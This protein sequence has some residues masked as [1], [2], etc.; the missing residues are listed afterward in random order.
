[1]NASE[2]P[3]VSQQKHEPRKD[4]LLRVTLALLEHYPL[5]QECI[6]NFDGADCDGACLMEDIKTALRINE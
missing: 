3:I 4:Y 2:Y 1:M 6:V 5:T